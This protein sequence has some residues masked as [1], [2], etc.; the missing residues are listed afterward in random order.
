MTSGRDRGRV[1]IVLGVL[2]GAVIVIAMGPL[3]S[4]FAG[5]PGYDLYSMRSG[6]MYPIVVVVG[7]RFLTNANIY[8]DAV[9]PR[10]QVI[11]FKVPTDGKTDYIKRVIGLPGD[12]IQLRAGRLYINDE[13]CDRTP[14]AGSLVVGDKSHADLHIYQE[15]LP[16]GIAHLIA[17]RGDDGQADN[18]ELF[19][20]PEGHVFML[21]DNR[22]NSSD[23]RVWGYVPLSLLRDKVLIVF[24]STDMSR[25]GKRIE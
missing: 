18:T 21:G 23:S 20:V 22:D 8:V 9:P 16:G 11:V 5:G 2:G 12:R 3:L 24:W 13:L 15:T 19:T 17:E 7:D 1:W 6:S 25:I 4:A 10:G 14:F